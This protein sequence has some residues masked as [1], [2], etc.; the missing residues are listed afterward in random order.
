MSSG[1]RLANA[2]QHDLHITDTFSEPSHITIGDK[3]TADKQAPRDDRYRGRQILTSPGKHG[4]TD[5]QLLQK[6]YV[7]LASGTPYVDMLSYER[8]KHLEETKK[9]PLK[10][11]IPASPPKK[12][13]GKGSLYGTLQKPPEH[14]PEG[15]KD[16]KK[17][18]TKVTPRNFVTNP[19]KK[20]SYGYYHTTIGGKEFEYKSEPYGGVKKKIVG[21]LPN[22]PITRP[23]L[24]T[25]HG[26]RLFDNKIYSEEGVKKRSMTAPQKQ[27]AVSVPFKGMS[28]MGGTINKFPEYVIPQGGTYRTRIPGKETV[29]EK[30]W[31]PSGTDDLSIPSKSIALTGL[32][33]SQTFMR[34]RRM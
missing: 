10:P 32:C 5:S 15:V 20:G 9:H 31:R 29:H 8:R 19:P 28:P 27:R 6:Q 21:Q 3:Y 26:D 2:A 34:S 17:G 23:F 30:V 13:V 7:P 4:R 1:D 11:F 18:D 33:E 25:S 16:V 12:S 24:S 14:M 22:K